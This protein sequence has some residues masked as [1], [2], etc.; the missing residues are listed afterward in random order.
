[1]IK[2]FLISF[3]DNF[4]EKTRNPFLG[5]YLI[6]WLVRNWKLVY[7]IFNFD[8]EHK[9]KDKID[10]IQ[11]YY[12]QHDFIENLFTNVYWAFGLFV[13]TYLLLNISR[14]IVNLSEKRM[15]PWIYKIS[16]SKSIVL[17]SEYERI[18]AER[19]DVQLRL[20]QERESKSKLESRIKNLEAELIANAKSYSERQAEQT[21]ISKPDNSNQKQS[22]DVTILLQK[23]KDKNLLKEFTET[24]V[25]INMGEFINNDYKPKD[26]FIEL[27]LIKFDVDHFQGFSKKYN[28]TVD[29]ES[30]LKRARLE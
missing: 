10:F 13:L 4:K 24:S 17:K 26:Y 28:L 11:N 20:D 22:D 5:T 7:T 6:V 8:S 25:M 27:G 9:L 12:S 19:D 21:T 23:L 15:T 29:G 30:L 3:T 1:M 2:D 18:R 16:D 14:L